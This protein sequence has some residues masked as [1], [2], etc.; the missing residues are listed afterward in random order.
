MAPRRG[1]AFRQRSLRSGYSYEF[2][3]AGE[4]F[5][6]EEGAVPRSRVTVAV[7]TAADIPHLIQL[8]HY[9]PAGTI[10]PRC[11]NDETAVSERFSAVLADSRG[12]FLLAS[13]A[14]VPA[15]MTMLTFSPVAPLSDAPTAHLDYTVVA[16][17]FRRRGVGRALMAAAA[18]I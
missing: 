16:A 10:G 6:D 13:F 14:G 2:S 15:G 18:G 3:Y 5:R 17:G 8:W 9:L 11:S 1:V 12:V 4:R 7:A